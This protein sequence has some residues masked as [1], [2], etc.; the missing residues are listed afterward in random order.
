MICF[1]LYIQAGNS[2]TQE[3]CQRSKCLNHFSSVVKNCKVFVQLKDVHVE[4]KISY[5]LYKSLA[6]TRTFIAKLSRTE[7]MT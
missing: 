7:K 5:L 3:N 4:A 2:R 6:I 1:W